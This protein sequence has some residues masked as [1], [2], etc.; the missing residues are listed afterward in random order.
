[1][2]EPRPSYTII[3]K[4]RTREIM[5]IDDKAIEALKD[6]Q[7]DHCGFSRINNG[8]ILVSI[9]DNRGGGIYHICPN[10]GRVSEYA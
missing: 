5:E 3:H 10:C 6:I 4:D 1:M 2:T 8:W 9:P 7:C